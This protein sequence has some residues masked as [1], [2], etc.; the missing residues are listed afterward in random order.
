MS[1]LRVAEI[2]ENTADSLKKFKFRKYQNTAAFILKIDKETL[3]IE[4]EQILEVRA[5]VHA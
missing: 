4:P 5:F 3:T 1:E 2:S